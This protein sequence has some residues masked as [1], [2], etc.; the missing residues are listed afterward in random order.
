MHLPFRTDSLA[1]QVAVKSA[2]NPSLW[3]C[4]VISIPLFV[5][6]SKTEGWLSIASFIVALV[7]VGAFAFS[8]LFLLF[9]NP[10]YLRSE[11]Y[12]LRMNSMRLLGD[13][14]NPLHANAEN[15]VSVINNP[16]LPP[17]DAQEKHD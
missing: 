14:D 8:Y 2:V 4:V 5:L 10:E 11:E 16:R 9:K 1:Q 3:A 15:I 13:K 6:A 7:P 12:Q 17:P